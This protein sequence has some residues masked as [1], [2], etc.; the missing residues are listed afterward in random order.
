MFR[1]QQVQRIAT[2]QQAATIPLTTPTGAAQLDINSI[3][4]MMLPMI[5]IVM[6]MKVMTGAI[7]EGEVEPKR[8][9]AS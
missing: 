3:M 4:A 6:M 5:I 9:K 7:G 8:I 1:P 2:P